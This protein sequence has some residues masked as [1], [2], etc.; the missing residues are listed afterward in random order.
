MAPN[1][2]NQ[3]TRRLVKELASLTGESMTEAVTKAVRERLDRLQHRSE[4]GLAA[5]LLEIGRNCAVRLKEPV[6]SG[7]S[8]DLLYD[9]QG[10][11]R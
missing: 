2:K 10:L 1:I 5:R 4:A 11:P 8:G 3:D 7:D 9:D 6:P